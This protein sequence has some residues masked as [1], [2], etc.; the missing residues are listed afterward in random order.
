MKIRCAYPDPSTWTVT[1]YLKNTACGK[2]KLLLVSTR[3]NIKNMK[4]K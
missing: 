4:D 2:E 3:K 1:V